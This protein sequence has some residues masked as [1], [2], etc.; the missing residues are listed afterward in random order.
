MSSNTSEHTIVDQKET[1]SEVQIS[2]QNKNFKIS[3]P[4]VRWGF[5]LTNINLDSWAFSELLTFKFQGV[6][7]FLKFQSVIDIR[8][9]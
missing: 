3:K 1:S 4:F 7:K 9:M 6:M 5:F 8:V 2:T